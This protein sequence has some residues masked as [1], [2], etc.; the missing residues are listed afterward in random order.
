MMMAR[1]YRIMI[2][3]MSGMVSSM[4]GAMMAGMVLGHHKVFLVLLVRELLVV[5]H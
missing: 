5:S 3:L 2:M 1:W 4:M